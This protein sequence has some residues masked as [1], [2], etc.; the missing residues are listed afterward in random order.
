GEGVRGAQAPVPLPLQPGVLDGGDDPPVRFVAPRLDPAGTVPPAQ[1]V[2]ADPERA[3]RLRGR[4]E[5]LVVHVITPRTAPA[6]PS[7]LRRRAPSASPHRAP[8]RPRVSSG[9]KDGLLRSPRFAP[10]T[11]GV[12][13]PRCSRSRLD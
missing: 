13:D 2:E 5:R 6:P 3:G 7:L 9:P 4:V 1:R 8:R 10:S 11:L 12:P